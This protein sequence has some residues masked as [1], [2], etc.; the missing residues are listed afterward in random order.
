MSAAS[1][2]SVGVFDSRAT[3]TAVSVAGLKRSVAS[4]VPPEAIRNWADAVETSFMPMRSRVPFV[5]LSRTAAV[6][7]GMSSVS[8]ARD[9]GA[10]VLDPRNRLGVN[11]GSKSAATVSVD[12]STS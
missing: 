6:D 12:A 4:N 7:T 11:S 9:S 8:L 3:V 2:V 1:A 5:I 10:K